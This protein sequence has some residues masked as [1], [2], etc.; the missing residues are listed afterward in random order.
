M[1]DYL[2]LCCDGLDVVVLLAFAW[3]VLRCI[4]L[5]AMYLRLYSWFLCV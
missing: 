4:M 1:F 3:C 2:V 5:V